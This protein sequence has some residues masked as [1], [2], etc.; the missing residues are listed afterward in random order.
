M[1]PPPH[2]LH[3]VC[4]RPCSQTEMPPPPHFLHLA[5]GALLAVLTVAAAAAVLAPAALPPVL[6]LRVL[7]PP[8]YSQMGVPAPRERM[9][10]GY[11][12]T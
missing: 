10:P 6:A 5:P 7:P 9:V 3:L 4:R 11:L 2:S 12:I 8:Q 1:L